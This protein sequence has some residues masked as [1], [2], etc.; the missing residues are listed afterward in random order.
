MG[1]ALGFSLFLFNF[2]FPLLLTFFDYIMYDPRILGFFFLSM[3]FNSL[4][5]AY[6]HNTGLYSTI[7]LSSFVERSKS[8]IPWLD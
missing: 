5:V 4:H 1:M 7:F 2:L 8:I 3:T 6:I